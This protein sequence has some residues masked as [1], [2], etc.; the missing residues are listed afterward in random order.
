[1]TRKR[2]KRKKLA[3]KGTI[4]TRVFSHFNVGFA[5]LSFGIFQNSMQ[6]SFFFRS[7]KHLVACYALSIVVID[8]EKILDKL[9]LHMYPHMK[10]INGYEI[11]FATA[12][13]RCFVAFVEFEAIYKYTILIS[14]ES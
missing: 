5:T 8:K 10:T 2:E 1:M 11:E 13:I 14:S 4:R 3:S 6:F 9:N 7:S 12:K